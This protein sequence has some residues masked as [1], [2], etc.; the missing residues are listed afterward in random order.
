MAVEL[1]E[2][3]FDTEVLNQDNPV[4]IDFWAPTWGP[5]RKL[6]PVIDELATDNEGKAKVVK[7][8]VNE[9]MPLA[10]KYKISMLPTIVVVKGSEVVETHVGPVSYTHLTLPTIYSV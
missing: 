4:L 2:T 1:N 7:V 9:N 5:C 6:G 10:A 8:N 3:N